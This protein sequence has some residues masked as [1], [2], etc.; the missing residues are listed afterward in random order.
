MGCLVAGV[1]VYAVFLHPIIRFEADPVPTLFVGSYVDAEQVFFDAC[2]D[3]NI[4]S[5]YLELAPADAYAR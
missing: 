2:E 1:D 3:E 4:D 5:F